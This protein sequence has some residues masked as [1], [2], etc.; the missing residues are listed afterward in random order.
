MSCGRSL[1]EITT[2]I[3]TLRPLDVISIDEARDLLDLPDIIT[4]DPDM[5]P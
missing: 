1:S 5:R 3:N 2:L 4:A